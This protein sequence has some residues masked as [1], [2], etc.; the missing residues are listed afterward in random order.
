MKTYLFVNKQL[1]VTTLSYLF[2]VVYHIA[3]VHDNDDDGD[4]DDGGKDDAEEE[5]AA[6]NIKQSYGDNYDLKKKKKNKN[7]NKIDRKKARKKLFYY[8]KG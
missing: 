3:L 1:A 8:K 6:V 5:A 7:K 4:D 2:K